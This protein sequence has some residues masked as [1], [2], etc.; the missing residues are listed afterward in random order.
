MGTLSPKNVCFLINV[1]NCL[2]PLPPPSFYKIMLQIC[3]EFWPQKVFMF[4][5]RTSS[6]WPFGQAWLRR[7]PLWAL[8]P[9]DPCT[10]ASVDNVV[11]SE[12][13]LEA[14]E[15]YYWPSLRNTAVVDGPKSAYVEKK[16][17]YQVWKGHDW[18]ISSHIIPLNKRRLSSRCF[19]EGT[20]TMLQ[21]SR[22]EC[23]LTLCAGW[24]FI[25]GRKD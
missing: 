21:K 8:R 22:K 10:N 7:S 4:Y 12:I 13:L 2:W 16:W 9:C 1:L 25:K 3:Q 23:Y 18:L 14:L 5:T 15:K 24:I 19:R 6:Q 11:L 17:H 20:R